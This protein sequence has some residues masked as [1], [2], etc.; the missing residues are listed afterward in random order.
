MKKLPGGSSPGGIFHVSQDTDELIFLAFD[1]IWKGKI[2]GKPSAI[3]IQ[4]GK[5]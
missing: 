5:K 3:T 2:T 4:G 1:Q